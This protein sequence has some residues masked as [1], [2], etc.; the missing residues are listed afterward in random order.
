MLVPIQTEMPKRIVRVKR[1]LDTIF[2]SLSLAEEQVNGVVMGQKRA[3]RSL[4]RAFVL[5]QHVL[6]IGPH[7]EAKSMIAQ[8]TIG[9]ISRAALFHVEFNIGT[10]VEDIFGPMDLR[11]WR[12]PENP[13]ICY[14]SAGYLP[15]CD[16]AILD[17]LF[18][19]PER[20]HSTMFS[21]L[22]E[23]RFKQGTEQLVC[24]LRSAVATTNF[25][26]DNP[27]LLAYLDRFHHVVQVMPLSWAQQH[28]LCKRHLSNSLDDAW[29][30]MYP[31]VSRPEL[32]RVCEAARTTPVEDEYL[33]AMLEIARLY[34]GAVNRRVSSRKLREST[35]LLQLA[36]LEANVFGQDMD[37]ADMELLY[38]MWCGGNASAIDRSHYDAAINSVVGVI[39]AKKSAE[40]EARH[41]VDTVDWS[42]LKAITRRQRLSP[43]TELVMTRAEAELS[44][45]PNTALAV[46]QTDYAKFY[47]IFKE[48][49][50]SLGE[51]QQRLQADKA[52]KSRAAAPVIES[53]P[54][55]QIQQQAKDDSKALNELFWEASSNT[56][57]L[58]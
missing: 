40:R 54:L 33:N 36:Q 37:L 5:K 20:L 43:A 2:N 48:A 50:V 58:K 1:P 32:S 38:P 19:A 14:R 21:I 52:E 39:A 7:G 22:N 11:K 10:Q 45:I 25:V 31:R 35:R 3:V 9:A 15:T 23:R 18:R 13:V 30:S 42:V 29:N 6:L 12:D 26:S 28:T 44:V 34:S 51:L 16:F 55:E 27:E 41:V 49:K 17:E 47:K 56:P 53:T 24:P 46:I 4:L 8:A 57:P